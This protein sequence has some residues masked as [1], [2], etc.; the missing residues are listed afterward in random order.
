[1]NK[2]VTRADADAKEVPR[3]EVL[4]SDYTELLKELSRTHPHIAAVLMR[5][6]NS[7]SEML[8]QY[9]SGAR[10]RGLEELLPYLDVAKEA[11]D[12]HTRLAKLSFL[13]SRA[14]DDFEVAIEATLSGA[15]GVVAD[16][17]RDVMEIQFLLRDFKDDPERAEDW[18]AANDKERYDRFRPAILRQ[19]Y[20]K[21]LGKQPEDVSEATDYKAH[22]R[23]VHVGPRQEL[24][25]G[26]G[27][28]KNE[29]PF[30]EDM[31]F[32]EMFEHGR[33]LIWAIDQLK[34]LLA[35]RLTSLPSLR[36]GLKA[37][38]DGWQ[39]TQE[40]QA[41]FFAILEASKEERGEE[42]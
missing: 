36:N 18:L 32:W 20:A 38:R 35:P 8:R 10:L 21:T 6:Q 19:R 1:M 34:R 16:H 27:F 24:F 12:R 9:L 14:R 33:R 3:V 11:F 37:F 15:R 23:A 28:A 40:M 41:M 25:G 42:R 4:E 39:R 29:V 17:M 31:C 2:P 5:A 26:K 22:S 7:R 13:L 30:A